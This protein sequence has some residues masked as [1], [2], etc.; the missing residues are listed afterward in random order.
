[1]FSGLPIEYFGLIVVTAS[2]ASIAPNNTNGYSGIFGK[3]I[4]AISPVFNLYFVCKITANFAQLSRN[5]AYV[6][7]LPVTPQTYILNFF[8]N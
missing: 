5:F 4:A 2:P 8:I 7:F 6:Y 1:M 3:H